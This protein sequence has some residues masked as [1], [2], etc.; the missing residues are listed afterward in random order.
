[1]CGLSPRQ[2]ALQGTE[3]RP[4]WTAARPGEDPAATPRAMPSAPV[5][6]DHAGVRPPRTFIP[7]DELHAG[8]ATPASIEPT[9]VAP[10][11][12]AAESAGGDPTGRATATSPVP[13]T[14]IT[15]PP[16]GD[17]RWSLWGELDV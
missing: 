1:M 9:T 3:V 17:G 8:P 6:I 5:M 7:V 4:C 10:A 13:G 14:P 15:G 16:T 11:A 12:S 2:T